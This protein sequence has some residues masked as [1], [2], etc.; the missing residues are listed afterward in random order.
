MKMAIKALA[1]CVAALFASSAVASCIVSGSTDRS[2]EVTSAPVL[3]DSG[4]NTHAAPEVRL[5]GFNLRTDEPTGMILTV[6]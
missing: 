5:D 1:A 3:I 6:R 2:A 4:L